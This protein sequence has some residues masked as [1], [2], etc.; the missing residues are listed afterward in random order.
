MDLDQWP[1]TI[2]DDE[3]I[4][5]GIC[6]PFHVSK[7]GELTRRAYDPTPNTDEVSVFR[8]DMIGADICKQKSKELENPTVKKVYRG[9][10]VLSAKKIREEEIDVVDS[11]G[12]FYG[13]A[14]IKHGFKVM[15]GETLKPEI[16]LALE[17]RNK[18]LAKIANY[19]PD[20]F[21][22]S[23]TWDGPPLIFEHIETDS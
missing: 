7:K 1:T 15:A 4:V 9:L 8:S 14:D 10:A 19:H 12:H 13:H 6:S 11:R 2:N 18:K 21:S 20:P 17:T 5:R 23:S 22:A 3:N 16:L